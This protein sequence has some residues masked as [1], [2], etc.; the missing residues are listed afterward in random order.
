M[1]VIATS[2]APGVLSLRG[3]VELEN[4]IHPITANPIAMAHQQGCRPSGC[5][6]GRCKRNV[7]RAKDIGL[8]Y[9]RSSA[10]PMGELTRTRD[11]GLNEGGGARRRSAWQD[12]RHRPD[13]TRY[14]K[15][16]VGT[17]RRQADSAT[18]RKDLQT[19]QKWNWRS[20]SVH[21]N[22]LNIQLSGFAAK[23][24]TCTVH[25]RQRTV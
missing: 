10:I 17:Q 15:K 1:S 25:L 5:R 2:T 19:P 3:R 14:D 20:T 8:P 24:V 12:Q 18:E 13:S 7:R 23:A 22:P 9:L 21:A 4:P 16:S 6:A 11:L